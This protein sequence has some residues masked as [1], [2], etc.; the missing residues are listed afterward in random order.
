[1]IDSKKSYSCLRSLSIMIAWSFIIHAEVCSFLYMYIVCDG[2][3]EKLNYFCLYDVKLTV[4][5]RMNVISFGELVICGIKTYYIHVSV[6][7]F[8]VL[9]IFLFF[10]SDNLSIYCNNFEY[11]YMGLSSRQK[12]NISTWD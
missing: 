12:Y 5:I 8:K 2:V 9:V 3:R 7:Q 1:M 4:V 11:I 6:V 10:V